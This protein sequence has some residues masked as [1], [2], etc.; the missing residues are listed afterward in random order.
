MNENH[1]H[2]RRPRGRGPQGR[3]SRPGAPARGER[4]NDMADDRTEENETH[5]AA[6]SHGFG[7]TEDSHAHG[8]GG[9]QAGA[10]GATYEGGRR[11]IVED[12]Q[13]F[14]K[15]GGDLLKRTV[16]SGIEVIKE[17]KKDLPKEAQQLI[18]KGKEEVLRGISKEVLQNVVTNTMDRFFA[19]VREHKLDITVSVRLKK[20]EAD[21][22][23]GATKER[24]RR[25]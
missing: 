4:D 13:D 8:P 12:L 3:D 10:H 11:F 9:S 15:I 18:S 23:E 24:D 5:G 16:S 14:A 21:A 7:S 6:P 25:R 2:G 1:P 22:R 20:A 17:V 19:V